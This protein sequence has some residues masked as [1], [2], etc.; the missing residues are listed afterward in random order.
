[1]WH[2]LIFKFAL[3]IFH[4]LALVILPAFAAAA[5]VVVASGVC[6]TF[7]K[8]C[9]SSWVLWTDWAIEQNGQ[10]GTPCT[11][12]QSILRLTQKNRLPCTLTFTLM[13]NLE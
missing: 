7:L 3:D 8:H 1:M 5:V 6:C 13:D 4:C 12:H 10:I 9:V 11:G 2:N